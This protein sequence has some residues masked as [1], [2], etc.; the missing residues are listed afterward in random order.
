[1]TGVATAYALATVVVTV[2]IVH[3]GAGLVGLPMAAVLG[4]LVPV[5]LAGAGMAAVVLLL[6]GATLTGR[7]PLARLAVGVPVG[8]GAYAAMVAVLRP[9]ALR[10]VAHVLLRST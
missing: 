7:G 1:M 6:D 8:I 3:L 2:P 10:E 5:L 4:R 9:R